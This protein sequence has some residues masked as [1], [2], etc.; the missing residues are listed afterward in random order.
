MPMGDLRLI[1][2]FSIKGGVNYCIKYDKRGIN[3]PV[4]L[5]LLYCIVEVGDEVF[6]IFDSNAK[7]DQR[8]P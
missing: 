3:T 1:L 7:P 6:G 8:I 4:I 2:C 5:L